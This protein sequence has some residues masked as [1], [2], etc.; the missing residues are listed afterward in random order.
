MFSF[1]EGRGKLPY[2][3]LVPVMVVQLEDGFL[4]PVCDGGRLDSFL[5]AHV[6]VYA[7][8]LFAHHIVE[9]QLAIL[10]LRMW[11]TKLATL[12]AVPVDE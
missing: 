7:P 12:L 9:A 8:R 3:D 4:E 6:R 2:A 5:P 1:R 11:I 10:R